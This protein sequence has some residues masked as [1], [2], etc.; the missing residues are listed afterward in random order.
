MASVR[1]QDLIPIALIRSTEG[2][3]DERGVPNDEPAGK[4]AS[5]REVLDCKTRPQ[6]LLGR[7]L[8]CGG[9]P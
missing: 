4:P 6:L 7:R 2:M 9:D 3:D 8:R 5:R 1:L